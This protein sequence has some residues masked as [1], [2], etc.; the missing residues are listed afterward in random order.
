MMK[1]LI[2]ALVAMAIMVPSWGWSYARQKDMHKLLELPN[3]T[4]NNGA[5]NRYYNF[6]NQKG[7]D[8][9]R[10]S[11]TQPFFSISYNPGLHIPYWVAWKLTKE[12]VSSQ[13]KVQSDRKVIADPTVPGCPTGND[14]SGV[15]RMTPPYSRGHM[16]PNADNR[17]CQEAVNDCYFM[18]NMVPQSMMMNAGRWELLESLCRSWAKQF[19]A[20]YIACGPVPEKNMEVLPFN[21]KMRIGMPKQ[22]FKV[23][24]R[25]DSKEGYKAIG[26]IFNQDN[27]CR[28]MTIDEVEKMTGLDFFHNVPE[29]EER[30]M[31]S[32]ME[33]KDWPRAYQ[34]EE[35]KHLVNYILASFFK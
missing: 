5:Q 17:W 15:G 26:W 3:F 6:R 28:S 11:M 8:D 2:L 29:K 9:K 13:Y 22:C 25:H 19:G 10:T 1:R 14:Y 32:K 16:C 7:N 24:M 20:V 21:K 18:T 27:T 34:I 30:A 33:I 12:H 35:K 4:T 23:V 31:E